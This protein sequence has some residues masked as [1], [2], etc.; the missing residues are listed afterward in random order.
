MQTIGFAPGLR[1]LVAAVGQQASVGVRHCDDRGG[2]MFVRKHC[3]LPRGRLKYTSGQDVQRLQESRSG[4]G[5]G[6]VMAQLR[7]QER[8]DLRAL[9]RIGLEVQVDCIEG[10]AHCCLP[11]LQQVGIGQHATPAAFAA[12]DGVDQIARP[13]QFTDRCR[14]AIPPYQRT[15][16]FLRM[17]GHQQHPRFDTQVGEH[18]PPQRQHA[19]QAWI[20]DRP[21]R[22]AVE[23]TPDYRFEFAGRR[24]RCR[25]LQPAFRQWPRI[26]PAAS[27]C[28]QQAVVHGDHAIMFPEPGG[29]V[30]A[31]RHQ[32]I[33]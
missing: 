25:R 11:I 24:I 10:P 12:T 18:T 8:I 1:G 23:I 15:G 14:Q 32:V 33:A 7:V 5:I 9:C 17:S 2:R 13:Q 21:Q 3:L 30:R 16:H 6:L 26:V 19:A 22:S 29:I 28:H 20:L 4:I 31:C 27:K